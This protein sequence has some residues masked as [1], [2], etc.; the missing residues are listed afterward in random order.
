M[1]YLRLC[2][3]F[4]TCLVV[5]CGFCRTTLWLLLYIVEWQSSRQWR[6]GTGCFV[7]W[8]WPVTARITWRAWENPL[9]IRVFNAGVRELNMAPSMFILPSSN[10]NLMHYLAYTKSRILSNNPTHFGARRRHLFGHVFETIWRFDKLTVD[11]ALPEDGA[12]E[13]WNASGYQSNSVTWCMKHCA[14]S[15][16]LI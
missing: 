15:V 11:M 3:I 6:A 10:Q 8:G 1:L 12:N 2:Y 7:L 9:K 13:R 4:I 5:V 16:G 14:L